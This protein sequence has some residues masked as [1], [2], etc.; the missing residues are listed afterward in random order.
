M[1]AG[2]TGLAGSAI[3]RAYQATGAEVI[4][5]NR[6][7][8][9]LLDRDATTAFLKKT[10]PSLVVDAAAKVGAHDCGAREASTARDHDCHGCSLVGEF[11]CNEF[12]DLCSI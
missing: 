6:S 4:A 10:K 5:V 2:G 3:V 7:V 8:V 12:C 1:V 11:S 9:D